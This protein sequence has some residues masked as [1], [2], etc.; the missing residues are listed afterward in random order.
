DLHA[1]AVATAQQALVLAER[2]GTPRLAEISYTLASHFFETG[3]WDDAL[4]EM[5]RV[6]ALPGAH[7]LPLLLHGLIALIAGHRDDQAAAQRFTSRPPTRT[8]TPCSWRVPWLP[9]ERATR[10]R[11]WTC[12]RSPWIPGL[13]RTCRTGM[14][15]CR[16]WCG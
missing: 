10:R 11:P 15:C 5:E 1:E 16:Y 13:R 9:S 6:S 3:Q 7:S 12:W 4:A 14:C 8:S 2:A